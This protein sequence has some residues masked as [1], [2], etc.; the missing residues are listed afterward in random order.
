MISAEQQFRELKR[1]TEEILVEADLLAKLK[2]SVLEKRPLVV[3][4]GFDPTAP[5]IHLGHTVILQKMAQFQRFGHRVIF[6]IGDFTGRVGDPSGRTKTRPQLSREEIEA[7]A[8]TYKTQ[9]FKILDS[10]ETHVLFNSEWLDKLTANEFITL[11]AK[12]NVARMLERDDFSRRFKEEKPISVHE[13]M[14]P[15]LQGYDS[16]H[17]KADVEM[18]GT[19]QKFNLLLGRE[20]MRDYGLEPQVCITL[21]LLEGLDGVQ[22]MS[23]SLDNYVGI[24]DPPA[25]MFGKLMSLP[26][27]MLRKYYD[28]LSSRSVDEIEAIF[29]EME[30]GKRNPRD[31][32]AELAA[33]I[34]TRFYDGAEAEKARTGF[35]KVFSRKELPDNM[36]E[37]EFEVEGESLWIPRLLVALTFASSTSEGKRLVNQ[38]AV[39]VDGVAV[40]DEN[41]GVE[42]EYLVLQ[43]GKRRFSKVRLIRKK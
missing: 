7:N 38:G 10:K 13:F 23:K 27:S 25:E 42:K 32:K 21:P 11:A 33:E 29:K 40:K 28:L 12:A 16:V 17:L 35:A 39:R 34:V 37:F 5:D 26:D 18:G 19:D 30:A 3:K 14:Y 4:V 36:V 1:G 22:K 6:L 41:L 24:A 31:V 2:R 43:C 20:L 8:E 15:L 9:V